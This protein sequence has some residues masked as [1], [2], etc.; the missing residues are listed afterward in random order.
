MTG[1]GVERTVMLPS[2]TVY[3]SVAPVTIYSLQPATNY[4][5][6]TLAVYP[7]N[8]VTLYSDTVNFTTKG[9]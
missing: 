9:A 1:D 8:N 7:I 2:S 5:L 6:R 3:P 4:T